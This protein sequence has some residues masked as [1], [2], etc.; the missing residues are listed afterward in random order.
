MLTIVFI[1]KVACN[2]PEFNNVGLPTIRERY[3]DVL[4]H[5][6]F[7]LFSPISGIFL[8]QLLV[9]GGAA[10]QPVTV[11][12]TVLGAGT[13]LNGLLVRGVRLAEQWVRGADRNSDVEH[14]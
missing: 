5:Q 10:S 12:I 13:A 3:R 1:I 11:A 8:Y 4:E 14:A 2:P 7:M 6:F 9:I